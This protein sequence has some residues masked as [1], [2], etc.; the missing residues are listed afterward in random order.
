MQKTAATGI[1]EKQNIT[2][3]RLPACTR[4]SFVSPNSLAAGS[5]LGELF[6][7]WSR[8]VKGKRIHRERK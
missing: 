6:F 7:L 8:T 1:T 3:Q 2:T 5:V 4:I